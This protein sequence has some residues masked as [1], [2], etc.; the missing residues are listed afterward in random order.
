M[1]GWIA[2]I[3]F[4]IIPIG[5][6]IVVGARRSIIAWSIARNFR[7]VEGTVISGELRTEVSEEHE[8]EGGI[9]SHYS[10]HPEIRFRYSVDGVEHDSG[11]Y[12]H[13]ASISAR[14]HVDRD[15]VERIVARFAAGTTHPAWYDPRRPEV[16]YLFLDSPRGGLW[17]IAKTIIIAAL[18]I[19]GVMFAGV[20]LS[21][22]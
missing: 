13:P 21:R 19:G 12:A 7:P 18:I 11:T 8:S 2:L 1:G 6:P 17:T 10:Y 20:M 4:V 14:T 16:A 3:L 9:R 15:R 5:I 22:R